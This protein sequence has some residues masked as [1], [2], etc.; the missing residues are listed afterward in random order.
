MG[1]IEILNATQNNLKNI[2]VKIPLG[3]ITAISGV[4]GSGKSS[5]I[6]GVLAAES[7]RKEK[8]DSGNADLASLCLKANVSEIKNL[9]YCEVLKQHRLRESVSSSIATIS[10]L[11]ELL[12]DEF[13]KN[14]KIVGKSGVINAPT[15][16]EILTFLKLFRNNAGGK[17]YAQ[18]CEDKFGS[19]DSEIKLLKEHRIDKVTYRH[20]D[21][22]DSQKTLKD[23]SK[24]KGG[25]HSVLVEIVNMQ[26]LKQFKNLA[27]AGFVFENRGEYLNFSRDFPDL[28]SGTLYAKPT[29]K[30]FSFN[31]TEFGSGRCEYCNGRGYVE[32]ISDSNLFTN[33]PLTNTN[34]I[35]LPFD[36][37]KGY[38]KYILLDPKV[39]LQECKKHKIDT[40]SNY[41]EL[42]LSEKEVIKKILIPRMSKHKNKES[43]GVFFHTI[44]CVK[45]S[46][47]RLNYKANAVKLFG[48]SISEFLSLNISQ[49]L[50]FLANKDLHHKKIIEI[51]KSLKI[52]TLEYLSL[53]R[54]TD[55]LSGGE[56][57]RLKLALILQSK[58]NELLYILDEPSV[59]LHPY[60][61][62]Q[63]LGLLKHIVHQ[64]N[65]IV[66]SDHNDDYLRHSDHIIKLGHGSGTQGGNIVYEGAY[67]NLESNLDFARKKIKADVQNAIYL[68]GVSFNNIQNE[69]FVIPLNA[70]VVI[71]GISGSGKSSLAK[72][73]LQ[74]LCIQFIES[75]SINHTLVKNASGLE[76]VK[77]VANL[78]QK[79]V[80]TNAR[81]VVATFLE[82]FDNLR[83]LFSAANNKADIGFFSFNSKS[84]QCDECKGR[85]EI[86]ENLCPVCLGSGFK[87]EVL[88]MT[89]NK[90]NITEVLD[91]D[92][93]ALTEFFKKD[94]IFIPLVKI[95]NNLGLSHLSLGRRLDSLSGGELQ[96]LALAKELLKNERKLKQGGVLFILDEPTRGLDS[97]NIAHLISILDD[98]IALGNSVV[99]IE[100]NTKFIEV[101]DFIID[102]GPGSGR[103]GGKN[104]FSGE[105]ENLKES[106][107]SITAKT[108]LNSQV[109]VMEHLDLIK[110]S[111][112]KPK[113][114]NFD[115]STYPFK[116]FLLDEGHFIN[117]QELAKNYQVR[118]ESEFRHFKTK[119]E[120]FEF[121]KTLDIKKIFFNPLSQWLYK[122]KIVPQSIKKQVIKKHKV[123][124]GD[125]FLCKVPC[126]SVEL[127]YKYGLGWLSVELKSGTSLVLGTRLVSLKKGIL[128]ARVITPKHFSLY[129]S[130][131]DYCRGSGKIAA[132]N[133]SLFVNDWDRSILEE[134]FLSIPL[135]LKL[136]TIISRFKSEGLFD[137]EI[138]F[139][140][141]SREHKDIFLYGFKAYKFLKAGGRENALGD[142]LAW[143]GLYTLIHENLWQIDSAEQIRASKYNVKCPFCDD[144]FKR[145]I[146]FY[147][148]GNIS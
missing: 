84:G 67:Q 140:S 118:M 25:G 48:K 28:E 148:M 69:N 65:T 131:C 145:E 9:P 58:H 81:S 113:T 2:S 66:L 17:L 13:V 139:K 76:R 41:F 59:G 119:E 38:Y 51:L 123:A 94:Q 12:R 132:Y 100:H 80:S 137:F 6:Y 44:A 125:D 55:T 85:G 70:L 72:G 8:N 87:A 115:K 105:I 130:G 77:Y 138:P 82:V 18:L 64:N 33:A 74:P 75:K 5:L 120:L 91:L 26:D 35:K 1:H 116:A 141:L 54:T 142:Y 24:L 108:L 15:C 30:L 16:E 102:I 89:F 83:E 128:G 112:L 32:D 134:G 111:N 36:S 14:G 88:D 78:S 71:S 104:V 126:D 133:A 97:K 124:V 19:L 60:N 39:I 11:H 37:A 57:Q 49:I 117:E 107:E 46:G 56:L 79:R 121:A 62:A 135:K 10:G 68:E 61:N 109:Q 50:D 95:L 146:G 43:I 110:N 101:C 20:T 29:S 42:G 129:V 3:K 122:Y 40:S 103:L 127:A 34:F 45:C 52:A 93:F 90:K 147:F 31:S 47:S 106:K 4:S 73:V 114:Y 99:V 86:E 136:K 53:N 144:G 143:D 23:L 63:I 21:R 22:G 98:L 96:R 7:L 27:K 92:M